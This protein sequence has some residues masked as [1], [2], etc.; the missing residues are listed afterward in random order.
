VSNALGYDLYNQEASD[1]RQG[2]F[3]NFL[4]LLQAGSGSLFP[5]TGQQIQSDRFNADQR[6]QEQQAQR[7]YEQQANVANMARR[8]PSING[9][10]RIPGQMGGVPGGSNLPWR[11]N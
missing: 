6:F 4:K 5:T 7:D 2:G 11:S 8:R 3:D 9:L 10:F 1:Y